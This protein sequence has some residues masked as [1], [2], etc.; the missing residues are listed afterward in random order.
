[1]D[2]TV[3][4]TQIFLTLLT[5]MY[6]FIFLLD[7]ISPSTHP[8][9]ELVSPIRSLTQGNPPKMASYLVNLLPQL[10]KCWNYTYKLSCLAIS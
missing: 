7:S 5:A 3:L 9:L 2:F 10:R 4:T 8:V 6:L 1:M